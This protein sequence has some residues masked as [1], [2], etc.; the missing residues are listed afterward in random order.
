MRGG[1][2]E[3][4]HRLRQGRLRERRVDARH[5]ATCGHSP[6]EARW[7]KESTRGVLFYGVLF[8]CGWAA[9]RAVT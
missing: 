5:A 4:G 3:A 6:Q 8:L 1:G 2:W 7:R 9:Q